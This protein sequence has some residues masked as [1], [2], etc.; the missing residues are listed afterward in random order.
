MERGVWASATLFADLVGTFFFLRAVS[1]SKLTKAG[2]YVKAK[3]EDGYKEGTARTWVQVLS[4]GY[5][6]IRVCRV[7]EQRSFSSC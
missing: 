1:S 6:R 7:H 5:G 2:A 4:N 3:R